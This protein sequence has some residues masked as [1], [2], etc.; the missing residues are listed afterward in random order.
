MA[1]KMDG[2]EDKNDRFV[3]FLDIMGFKERLQRDGDDKVKKMLESLLPTI[4][5]V[6]TMAKYASTNKAGPAIKHIIF[7]DSIIVVSN[8]K[9]QQAFNWI[10]FDTK[11]IIYNAI[12]QSIPIKGAIAFGMQTAD[13][14]KS[15][16]FGRPLIDAHELQNELQL[17]GIVLHHTCEKYLNDPDFIKKSSVKRLSDID[18]TNYLVPMKSG[19]ISHY[20]VNWVSLY[21]TDRIPMNEE[22]DPINDVSN[23]YNIVSGKPRIY[24]DNTLKYVRE[25]QAKRLELEKKK[26]NQKSV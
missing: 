25:T 21:E 7:S 23:L 3:A 26:G 5:Y 22:K 13:F 17:Y 11:L 1:E 18:I 12:I 2:W 20:L 6:E 8:D 19:K 10:I 4:D 9:S 14:T 16:H 15:L 24:V